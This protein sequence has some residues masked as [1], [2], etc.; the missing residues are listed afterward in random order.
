MIN[1][2]MDIDRLHPGRKSKKQKQAFRDDVQ[3]YVTGLGYDCRIEQGSMGAQNIVIGD[4][5]KAKYLVTA[6]FWL[7]SWWLLRPDF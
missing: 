3:R 5:E 7:R 4:P 2:P 6:H 1:I